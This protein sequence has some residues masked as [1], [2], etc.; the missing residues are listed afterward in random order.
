MTMTP[1]GDSPAI[2]LG[3]VPIDCSDPGALADFY[4]TLLGMKR[5][6]ETADGRVVAISDGIHT[7]AMMRTDGYVEPSWP[8][9]GQLQ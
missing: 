4:G 5:I 7:L 2:R 8:E 1:D 3:S 6:V 9:R